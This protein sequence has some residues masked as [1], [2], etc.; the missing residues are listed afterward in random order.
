MKTVRSLLKWFVILLV[1]FIAEGFVMRVIVRYPRLNYEEKNRVH[2]LETDCREVKPG[3][4]LPAALSI[5]GRNAEPSF[6][7]LN[8]STLLVRRGNV[9]CKAELEAATQRVLT[10][11]TQ[12]DAVT[13]DPRQQ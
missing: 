11:E 2:S 7:S 5:L 9:T 4:D 8:G 1:A 12:I 3:Y 6:E 10:V 13:F